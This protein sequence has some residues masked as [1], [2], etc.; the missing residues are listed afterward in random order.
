MGKSENRKKAVN[1]QTSEETLRTIY[2]AQWQ[3]LHHCRNQDWKLCNLI[4]VGLLGIGGLKIFGELPNLQKIA[5]LVFAIVSLLAM[6]VTERHRILFK[7]KMQAIRKL[8]ELLGA[9]PLFVS[10][11][12]WQRHFKVQYLLILIYLLF[13][14]FFFYLAGA[15]LS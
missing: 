4:I 11:Q 12:G 1:D 5:S 13:A 6:G 2:L 3:D 15:G 7:E 9:P 8:E 10:R 14:V